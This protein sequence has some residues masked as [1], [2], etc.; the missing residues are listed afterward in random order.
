MLRVEF[1]E[2]TSALKDMHLLFR[3]SQHIYI[4]LEL[5]HVNQLNKGDLET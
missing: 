4:D 3:Q 2:W 5:S 1:L